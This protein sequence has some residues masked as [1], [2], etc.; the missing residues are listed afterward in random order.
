MYC[1]LILLLTAGCTGCLDP[2]LAV[3]GAG[4]SSKKPAGSAALLTAAT[5]SCL[6]VVWGLNA[7]DLQN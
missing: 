1:F 7:V 2:K 5:L 3:E 6:D 4:A